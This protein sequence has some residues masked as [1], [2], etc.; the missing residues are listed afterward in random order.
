MRWQ[1]EVTLLL[2][3]M[4][5]VI[6]YCRWNAELW[7]GREREERAGID[8]KSMQ[9]LRAFAAEQANI[10]HRTADDLESH[11]MSICTLGQEL[12]DGLPVSR[13]IEVEIDNGDDNGD[14]NED[15][16]DLVEE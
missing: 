2:E 14:D 10:Q 6:A 4:R 15:D 12:L 7:R 1:E 13:V 3:E 16:V 11:W 8:A 9:G 5:R